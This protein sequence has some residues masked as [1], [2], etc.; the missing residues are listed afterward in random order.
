MLIDHRN[1]IVKEICEI[2]ERIKPLIIQR[3]VEFQNIWRYGKDSDIFRELVFCILTP[4]SRARSAGKALKRLYDTGLITGG[5]EQ[6]IAAELN[7]VRFRYKKASYIVQ[8]RGRFF[9]NN[10]LSLKGALLEHDS[11]VGRRE[12]LVSN[13]KGVGYKEASHFLR[14][15][16]L[17]L[18]VAI[19][20]RHILKNLFILGI[21]DQVPSHISP[22]MY[23]EIEKRMCEYSDIMS[24]PVSHLDFVLWY[25]ETGDVFK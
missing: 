20:D 13:I 15:I 16:G 14:N 25:R 18:E 24:I 4:S 2:Y 8:A 11:T 1:L 12:W 9:S 23:L 3:I 19:L 17:D 21:I 5:T 22:R 7:I 10:S 6:K